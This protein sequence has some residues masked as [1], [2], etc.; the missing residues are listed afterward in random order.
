[1]F[2]GMSGN[3]IVFEFLSVCDNIDFEIFIFLNIFFISIFIIIIIIEVMFVVNISI[4][5]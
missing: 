4:I 5:L 3:I 2:Y 1:M